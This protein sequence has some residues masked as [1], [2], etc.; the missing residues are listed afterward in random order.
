MKP[1]PLTSS[2][3]CICAPAVVLCSQPL[4]GKD[5][6]SQLKQA[7]LNEGLT[8]VAP[9]LAAEVAKGE[10]ATFTKLVQDTRAALAE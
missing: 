7:A 8:F 4:Y 1:A 6:V 5:Y 2:I 10:M 3:F 9:N